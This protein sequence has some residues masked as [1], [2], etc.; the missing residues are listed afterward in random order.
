M[1]IRVSE[2]YEH[3]NVKQFKIDRICVKGGRRGRESNEFDL[4]GFTQLFSSKAAAVFTLLN[5]F[6]CVCSSGQKVNSR[7]VKWKMKLCIQ[8]AVS[9]S[10]GIEK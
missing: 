5:G 1:R 9:V 4:N 6:V 7:S 3:G 2:Q 10:K 8:L